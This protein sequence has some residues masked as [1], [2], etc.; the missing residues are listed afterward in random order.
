MLAEIFSRRAVETGN[1]GFETVL[2]QKAEEGQD[3]V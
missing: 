2:K 1:S 3:G